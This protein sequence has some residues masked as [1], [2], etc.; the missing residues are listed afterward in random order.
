MT[1]TLS[2]AQLLALQPVGENRFRAVHNLDNGRGAI[3]GGQPLVQGLAAAALTAHGWQANSMSAQYLRSGDTAKP[4]DFVVETVRD[5]RRYAARR[6]VAQQEGKPIFDMLCSF[7]DHEDGPTHVHA[8]CPETPPPEELV[9]VKAF[10]AANADRLPAWMV[11]THGRDFPIELRVIDPEAVFFKRADSPVRT[12]W[13][14]M[15]TAAGITR[16]QHQ[17]SLLAFM[18]DFYLAG[19]PGSLHFT[20]S[21]SINLAVVTLNHAMWF[22][23][24]VQAG[25]WLKFHTET[26]WA[27]QGR[28]LARGMIFDRHG[29]L[30]ANVVQEISIR[31]L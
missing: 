16:L 12:Y 28:G 29:K 9:S 13:L 23:A 17:Q 18:S 27:G 6:V 26:P 14:R 24:P 19:T 2:A 1:T 25:E 10:M 30:A 5:G 4:L 15:P 8:D 7:H 21:G 31:T 3:F 22:H 11:A 20:P